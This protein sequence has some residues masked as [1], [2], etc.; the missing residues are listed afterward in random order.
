[1][2]TLTHALSGA[3]LA[4]ATA[5]RDA[6]PR[7][8]PRRIAAGFFACAFPDID[9]VIGFAGPVEYLLHHRG[10]THSILLAP[11]WAIAVAWVLAK[12]LREPRGWRAL[13]GVSVLGIGAHIAGDLI[14]SFGTMI[15]APL[16]TARFAWGTTFIID[17]WFTG[18]ILAGLLASALRYRSRAPSVAAC[19]ILAGYVCVQGWAKSEALE[20]AARHAA[21]LG[22]ADAE[23]AAYPRAVSP[24]NWT[25]YVSDDE[26]HRYAHINLVR[27]QARMAEPGDG[28][29]AQLDAPFLPVAEA[30]WETRTRFGAT[31]EERALARSAWESG[32]LD[33]FRWFA[34][35]P[36]FDGHTA[37]SACAWFID[38]RF[39]NPGRDWVPFRFGACRESPD[40]P[41]LPYERADSGERSRLRGPS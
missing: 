41:W 12:I 9:F 22:R 32:A 33:F 39:V 8:L 19:A 21:S 16:S 13:Y 2:D 23:I 4:R 11:L 38:L 10:S 34:A 15:L 20:F 18:I 36:A 17:P 26:L 31:R 27:T 25:V 5:S 30:R 28:F 14:T 6:P 35:K 40:A 29:V 7:S 3:L 1:V 24:F 37:G